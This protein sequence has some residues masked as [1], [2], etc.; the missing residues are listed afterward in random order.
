MRPGGSD[1]LQVTTCAGTL[2]GF[3][4]PT[5]GVLLSSAATWKPPES[6]CEL[7]MGHSFSLGTI[8]FHLIDSA[9]ASCS[10]DPGSLGR[11]RCTCRS[12]HWDSST[13]YFF[14]LKND[15]ETRE[16]RCTSSAGANE[17]RRVRRLL[18][19]RRVSISQMT[20]SA[21][22]R[23]KNRVKNNHGQNPTLTSFPYSRDMFM[24]PDAP[25]LHQGIKYSPLSP[26]TALGNMQR[27]ADANVLCSQTTARRAHALKQMFAGCDIGSILG[28]CAHAEALRERRRR[29]TCH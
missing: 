26:E 9:G 2:R 5:L 22:R 27:R 18:G 15:S 20:S 16:P 8:S 25:N 17:P 1:R 11:R 6:P 21:L 7:Q 3:G 4:R 19:R 12:H 10:G 13:I 24:L 14:S 29:K 23:C 28:E